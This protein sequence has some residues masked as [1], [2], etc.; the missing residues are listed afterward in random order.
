M[1]LNKEL[2]QHAG[3]KLSTFVLDDTT[4]IKC[5]RPVQST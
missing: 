4:A 5:N 2:S 3:W 1:K